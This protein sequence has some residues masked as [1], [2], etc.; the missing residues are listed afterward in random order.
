MFECHN[1]HAASH[2]KLLSEDAKKVCLKCHE[3]VL[4]KNPKSTHRVVMEGNCVKCHDPHASNN[5]F[6]LLKAGNSLCIECHKDIGNAIAKAKFKHNPVEKGCMD[7]HDPH[8][9]GK[10]DKLLK[11]DLVSLCTSCHK[12]DRPAFARQHV[13]Y[14]VAKANCSS[15]HDPHGSIGGD[16]FLPM[17]MLQW[18]IVSAA[19]ATKRQLLQILLRQRGQAMNYA[20]PATAA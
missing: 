8:G 5:K 2:G 6:A 17:C 11:T 1:P 7:C 9:S 3:G 16:F 15:C 19:S 13:D 4:P 14:P 10:S 12:T 18:P 20:E